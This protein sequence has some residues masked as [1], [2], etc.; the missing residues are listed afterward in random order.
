M[1]AKPPRVP[2]LAQLAV[3]VAAGVAVGLVAGARAAVLGPLCL[4]YIKLLKVLATPLL[5]AAIV[6]ALGTTRMRARMG[7]QL[8]VL[9]SVNALVAAGIAIGLSHLLPLGRVVDLDAMRRLAEPG[10]A[11]TADKSALLT[12]VEKALERL[13]V[14][15]LLFVIGVAMLVG[16][17]VRLL[18]HTRFSPQARTLAAVDKRLLALC[19][20]GLGWAV[21]L[22]PLAA[23]GVI[24]SVIGRGGGRLFP[25]LGV[26]VLVV[27]T[28]IALHVFVYYGLL[29]KLVARRS[30]ARFFRQA[31]T[32]LATA[33]SA[34]SSLATLP[35]TL[36]TLENEMQV[37][38]E[39]AR[40]AACVGTN[41]NHDG[42]VLYEAAAALFVAQAL[43]I[44]LS[45]GAQLKMVAASILAA[46][47]IAGVPEAGLITLSLVLGAAGLPLAAVPLL[48][49]VDWLVGRL[50]AA[51]N[52]ASDLTVATLL[53]ASATRRAAKAMPT[54]TTPTT[55]PP[56]GSH[57]QT[58]H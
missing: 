54:T 23:F 51:A 13:T 58:R 22:V 53:D 17:G 52:V 10:G 25:V 27:A 14:H 33:L 11:A 41:L 31:S 1:N 21:R 7:A 40:L 3:A 38:T 8:L 32:P 5:F 55:D 56:T 30:P 24:A 4:L 57:E 45:F 36:H 42:I 46:V 49:P 26:F 39:A 12:V 37:S 18:S 47:G 6:D 43:S 50:R 15:N 2:V 19:L 20:R 16:L 9:S 44:Q 28:G 48:L 29:L 35:V 34:A